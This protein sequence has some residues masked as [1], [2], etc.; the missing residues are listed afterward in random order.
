MHKVTAPVKNLRELGKAFK[1]L[2]DPDN[3]SPTMGLV[4]GATGFGKSTAILWLIESLRNSKFS[5]LG[6]ELS[7]SWTQTTLL[8]ELVSG[9]GLEPHH[10]RYENEKMIINQVA[11]RKVVIFVDEANY[12]FADGG[13]MLNTLHDIWNKTQMPIVLFG[14]DGIE[15]RITKKGHIDRRIT[16]RVEFTALDPTD[17]Q[18]VCD[19]L[20]EVKIES[21]LNQAIYDWAKG[22]IAYVKIAISEVERVAKVNELKAIT[23]E[24]WGDRPF[25]RE[26]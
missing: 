19:A 14:R 20:C 2:S 1:V 18:V 12:L 6:I 24:Y 7:D 13:K 25:R 22:S 17:C 9:L 26:R 4:Y 3:V 21:C 15:R 16:Q 11:Q 10:A 8:R 5:G 23:A